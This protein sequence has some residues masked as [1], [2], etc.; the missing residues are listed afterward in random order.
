L[1]AADMSDVTEDSTKSNESIVQKLIPERISIS[2][3][4]RKPL[5]GQR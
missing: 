2:I 4:I 3:A 5:F 1:L